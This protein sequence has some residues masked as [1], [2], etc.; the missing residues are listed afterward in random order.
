M[1]YDF[2]SI[3]CYAESVCGDSF[4]CERTADGYLLVV[5]DGLGHGAKANVLSELTCEIAM[6]EWRGLSSLETLMSMLSLRLPVNADNGR[7]YA[8]FTLI[9]YNERRSQ[10]NLVEYESP[11]ALFFRQRVRYDLHAVR[12]CQVDSSYALRVS[13][14]VPRAGDRLVVVSD[15]VSQSGIGSPTMPFGWGDV[16][17]SG[18]VREVLSARVG[19][20]PAGLCDRLLNCAL[21][22][23]AYYAHDDMSVLCLEF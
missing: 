16:G 11:E 5:S 9:D 20:S 7:A 4:L 19:I 13:H 2:Q 17:V 22:N 6:S 8:T 3:N 23:E 1:R 10:V 15:G 14:V 21:S 18:C 12:C